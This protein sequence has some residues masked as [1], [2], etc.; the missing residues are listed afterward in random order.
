VRRAGRTRRPTAEF[1][2]GSATGKLHVVVTGSVSGSTA[3]RWDGSSSSRPASAAAGRRRRAAEA[4]THGQSAVVARCERKTKKAGK[5]FRVPG[6][7]S[8]YRPTAPGRVAGR[9]V[10]VYNCLPARSNALKLS[11]CVWSILGNA[12]T[13]VASTSSRSVATSMY[14]GARSTHIMSHR[15]VRAKPLSHLRIFVTNLA[16]LVGLVGLFPA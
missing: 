2:S 10:L 14:S 1:F 12:V 8:F 3:S 9:H 6:L 5:L 16:H 13:T 4:L 15:L 7:L 11:I